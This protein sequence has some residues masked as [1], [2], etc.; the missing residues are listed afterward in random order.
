MSVLDDE[1]AKLKEK[2]K[3]IVK[4]IES[5]TGLRLKNMP[6]VDLEERSLPFY[7]G[8]EKNLII[9]GKMDL[10]G[11][12][13]PE[14]K[15]VEEL[16]HAILFQN[17]KEWLPRGLHEY[18][19][20]YCATILRPVEDEELRAPSTGRILEREMRDIHEFKRLMDLLAKIDID[21]YLFLTKF[22]TTFNEILLKTIDEFLDDTDLKILEYFDSVNNPIEFP[23]FSYCASIENIAGEIGVEQEKIERSLEKLG[24]IA[25]IP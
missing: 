15:L 16:T 8:G 14:R 12:P 25:K 23:V 20:R 1:V 5:F 11:R 13:T 7:Y 18:F 24:S 9:W 2:M 21:V 4:E 17:Q 22:C 10:G 6:D 19:S 3:S